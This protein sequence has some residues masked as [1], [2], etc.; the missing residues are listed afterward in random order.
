ML[1]GLMSAKGAVINWTGTSGNWS[2]LTWSGGVVPDGQDASVSI[3]TA[4]STVDLVSTSRTVGSLLFGNATSDTLSSTGGGSLIFSSSVGNATLTMATVNGNN[5]I[6]APITLN[7]SLDL[8]VGATTSTRLL[9]LNGKIS[10]VGAIN[11]KSGVGKLQLNNSANDFSGGVI[12]NAGGTISVTSSNTFLGTGTFT[13]NGGNIQT[14]SAGALNIGGTGTQ[15]WAGDFTT[16]ISSGNLNMGAAA[17]NLNG[18]TRTITVS[19]TVSNKVTTVGGVISNGGLALTNGSTSTA[20]LLLNG[21]NTYSGTT[22]VN[23]GTL[24]A[25]STQAF[26]I[27]SAV[28]LANDATATLDL[29]SNNNSIGSLAGGGITGGNV[30]LGSA[31]LTT[32]GNNTSTTYSG[33]ISGT[34]GL[35]KQG[36]GV[37]T[38]TGANIY[39]TGGTVINAGTLLAN[40]TSGSATGT[41]ALTVNSTGTFGGSGTVSGAATANSGSFL[42]PGASS[43]AVGTL[44][45]ASTLNISGLAGGSSGLLFNLDTVGA[46]DKIVSGALTIGSGVLDFNDF[47]FTTLGGYG[48]GDYTLFSASSIIGT[49]GSNLTG[50]VGGL[51]GSLAVVGNDVVLSVT[52]IPEPSTYAAIAGALTLGGVLIARRRRS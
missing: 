6:S 21:L 19:S 50:T 8:T 32:G 4:G 23:S 18:G 29:N 51:N 36:S 40:N 5:T 39:S 1:A 12:L 49:L 38:L 47:S 48:V 14:A 46:S 17:V 34:G 52:A 31:I 43:G 24:R 25:G 13:I 3:T 22:T 16:A 45:F 27:N 20:A 33:I 26:G 28:S 15:V 44:T 11:I 7:S 35:V 42:A 41:G 30:T 37:F 2:D 10:G 9:V